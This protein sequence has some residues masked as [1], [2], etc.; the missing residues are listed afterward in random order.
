MTETRN[1]TVTRK[2]TSVA[3]SPPRKRVT[4]EDVAERALA[5]RQRYED[6]K[7]ES[8]NILLYGNE[9]TGKT[10]LLTTARKPVLLASFDPG[11]PTTRDLQPLIKRGD[12]LVQSYSGDV[13]LAPTK[14][15]EWEDDFLRYEAEGFFEHIGTYAIDS[16]TRWADAMMN[17]IVKKDGFKNK[18]IPDKP[19]YLVEQ[20]TAV[21]YIG[22]FCALPCDIIFTGHIGMEK[23][24]VTG[25]IFTSLLLAGKLSAKIPLCFDEKYVTRTKAT[26]S[27]T[28]YLLQVHNDGQYRAETRMGGDTLEMF[29]EPNLKKLF[30]KAGFPFEDKPRLFDNA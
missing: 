25:Q 21:D 23:D 3:A 14:F 28:Q 12:I 24:D 16:G 4:F 18:G 19:H 7:N 1:A 11:G 17:E 13:R 27:G 30:A 5:I 8:H 15:R 29:E 6:E 22:R 20:L 2:A 26:P 10:R 9:G